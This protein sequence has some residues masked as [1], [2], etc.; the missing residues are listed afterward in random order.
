M[1]YPSGQ[2][3]LRRFWR[4]QWRWARAVAALAVATLLLTGCDGEPLLRPDDGSGDAPSSLAQPHPPELPEA[5]AAEHPIVSFNAK[6]DSHLLIVEERETLPHPGD[7][8]G[9]A[10]LEAV[11]RL[12]ASDDESET[13]RA[14]E[15][16]PSRARVP[17]ATRARFEIVFEI[18]RHGIDEGGAFTVSPE[19]FWAWSEAQTFD[20]G[21]PGYVTLTAPDDVE[22]VAS[23]FGEA[24]FEVRGRALRPGER[25]EIV[26][27][28]SPAGATVDAYAERGAELLVGVD[29]DG[30]GFRQWL[31]DGP[32]IDVMAREGV[33]LV[34]FAPAEVAPGARF[35][36]QIALV[37]ALGNRARWPGE[38]GDADDRDGAGRGAGA[39]A[40]EM[41]LWHRFEIERAG[42]PQADFS[43]IPERV[44]SHASRKGPHRIEVVAP[45]DEGTLRLLV[46]GRG[47]LVGLEASVNPI[48]VRRARRRLVWGDLH[49]HSRLSDGTGQ[50]EDYYAYARDVARLDV[51]ALTD[52]DHWGMRALDRDPEAWPSILESVRRFHAPGRFVTLPGYEWTS[53]LHGHRHVLY[54]A[55]EGRVHSAFDAETDRPDELWNALRGQPALTFAHHSAGEPVA[56][57]WAF[58]P[59]PELEPVTEIAS[60]HGSSE[61]WDSPDPVRGAIPG[62][63]VRDELLRG[64]RLGFIG[65]GDSHDG[66][67][68]L[69]QLAA[70]IG[71]L[72]GLFVESLD[73]AGVR[74]AF[75]RRHSFATN[76]IRPWMEVHIDDTPMGS[77]LPETEAGDA[78]SHRLWIRYEGTDAIEGVDLVRSGVVARLEAEELA[79]RGSAGSVGLDGEAELLSLDF[80]RTIPRLS[81]GDF[82]YVRIRQ[83]DGGIAWSSPIFATAAPVARIAPVAQTD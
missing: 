44:E 50:P 57:N 74:D 46:R 48:V 8:G 76:G 58:R 83:K 55:N 35:A 45:E 81:P 22:L 65:S 61:A 67:P 69:P 37:D 68:G 31:R 25:I 4:A 30:D 36:L 49:G 26:Y 38:A 63:F 43:G 5:L 52:H 29:A 59:D 71:G 79:S 54:F 77:E 32:R 18:G 75:E 40:A 34:A 15:K 7:G 72:A 9:R 12:D 6:V 16:G 56:V 27:G 70:G 60:V 47:S 13:W 62:H 1:E 10:W 20:A 41:D 24:R 78:G 33:S 19:P 2:A 14:N 21:G 17:A 39:D 11:T 42:P 53:W 80:E 82:H 66:H 23:E 51:A 3:I 64:S 28:D 73:R